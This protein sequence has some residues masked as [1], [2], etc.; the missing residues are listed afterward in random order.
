MN[1]TGVEDDR[2]RAVNSELRTIGVRQNAHQVTDGISSRRLW[3]DVLTGPMLD[4]GYLRE[5]VVAVSYPAWHIGALKATKYRQWFTRL[6][7]G[8]R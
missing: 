4:G 5:Q 2:H 1:L 8:P 6:H 7:Q 3:D